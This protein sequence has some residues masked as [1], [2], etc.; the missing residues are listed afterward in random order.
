MTNA[1]SAN[2]F[3][4]VSREQVGNAISKALRLY[5]GRGRRY[6]VKELS[7]GTGIK[8]RVIECAICRADSL[9]YRPLPLEALAS[10]GMFLGAE[11]TNQW[12]HIM[13]QGAFD[14]PDEDPDP[15]ELAADNSDDN[16]IITRAAVDGRFDALERPSLNVVGSR[17]V[18]RGSQLVAL[19][20]VKAA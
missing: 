10:I 13:G 18:T 1:A 4:L 9:D 2:D 20:K 7:N 5:V 16:A 17:L 14:L 8:D 12:C 3:I 19:G 15:G 11:F 6:S